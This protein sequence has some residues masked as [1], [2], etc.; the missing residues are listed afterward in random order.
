MRD[1]TIFRAFR[2]GREAAPAGLTVAEVRTRRQMDQFVKLP[3]RIYAD[4]P[5][6]VPP[7]LVDVKESLDPRH[8]PFYRHGAGVRFLAT[9]D[10]VAVGRI[11]ASD[12]PN[13]NAQRGTNVGCFGF[14]ETIDDAAV[15]GALLDAAANWLRGRGRASMMGPMDYSTNYPCGLLIEGFDT[16]PRVM[17]NHNPPYYAALLESWGLAKVKDLYAWWFT[18]PHDMI[19]A[20]RPRA[21]RLEKRGR[22]TI[23]PFRLKDFDA[24]VRRCTEVYNAT[25]GENWGFV[26]LTDAEFRYL[27]KRIA[28]LANPQQVLLA[29]IDGKTVGFSITLPDINEATGPLNGRLTTFGLPIG[30]IRLFYLLRRVKTARM[31]VLG[32]LEGYRRRGIAELLI[33]KTLDYGKNVIGYTGAE[34]GW[35]LE[36]NR[37]VNRTVEAV[38]AKH[39]KTYRIYEKKIVDTVNG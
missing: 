8:H 17:M 12:D 9:R 39:Y 22:V 18:D 4:D 21:E 15:S 38:G 35:T 33:L 25:I 5:H 3:W 30:L 13:Y 31:V 6:W 32:L 24:E 19:A 23:R 28:Q 20:W 37:S 36:D 26:R 10:G 7:L 14:F 2:R 1:W 29:E 11:L 16:P 34:L 27:A